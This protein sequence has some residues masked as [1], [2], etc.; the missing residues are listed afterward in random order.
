MKPLIVQNEI[1]AASSE[2]RIKIIQRLDKIIP[3]RYNLEILNQK[4]YKL[5]PKE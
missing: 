2:K 4:F 1:I 3:D 5:F